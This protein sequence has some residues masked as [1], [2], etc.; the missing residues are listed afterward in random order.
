MLNNGILT[1][2]ESQLLINEEFEKIK[3]ERT[4]IAVINAFRDTMRIQ[5]VSGQYINDKHI[6]I[7]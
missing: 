2:P 4:T 6:Q 3:N 5:T 1:N 7:E